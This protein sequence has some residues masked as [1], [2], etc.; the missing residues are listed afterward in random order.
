MLPFFC[1]HCPSSRCPQNFGALVLPSNTPLALLSASKLI[2]DLQSPTPTSSQRQWQQCHTVWRHLMKAWALVLAG[3]EGGGG[4]VN[5]RV[6]AT[7]E[8]LLE[9]LE[10]LAESSDPPGPAP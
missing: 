2:Q 4:S 6:I 1:V 8:P 9:R 5:S 7:R 10:S 3:G